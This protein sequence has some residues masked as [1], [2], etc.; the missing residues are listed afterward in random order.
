MFQ[1]DTASGYHHLGEPLSGRQE[2]PP[3][4]YA[5]GHDRM[6]TDCWYRSVIASLAFMCRTTSNM[7]LNT[8]LY[9]LTKRLI[10]CNV[11]IICMMIEY[12][13]CEI[14]VFGLDIKCNTG[15]IGI[16]K[17]TIKFS[18]EI[19]A[20]KILPRTQNHHTHQYGNVCSQYT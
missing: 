15:H 4:A 8:G 12:Y 19:I 13:A 17:I 5:T 16:M 10:L 14:V 2:L 18:Q 20:Y 7:F 1:P 11:P 9:V 3:F 6:L